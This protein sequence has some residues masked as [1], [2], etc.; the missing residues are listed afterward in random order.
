[1]IL[2]EDELAR[3][4]TYDPDPSNWMKRN[5][6]PCLVFEKLKRE[7]LRVIDRDEF[8]ILIKL[9]IAEYLA[10]EIFE[11]G[12]CSH[13]RTR[14]EIIWRSIFQSC[15]KILLRVLEQRKCERGLEVEDD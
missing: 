11:Y 10:R 14:Y 2:T 7:V 8:Q 12:G 4:L 1:M 15:R 9:S 6:I 5:V 13:T 3:L